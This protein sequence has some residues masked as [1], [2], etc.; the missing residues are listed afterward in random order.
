MDGKHITT[1]V[2]PNKYFG[3]LERFVLSNFDT[4][5]HD[6]K[7]IVIGEYIFRDGDYFR[8]LYPGKRIVFY[9]W[10]Q[11]V[12]NN[13]YF[14]LTDAIRNLKTADEVWDYDYLNVDFL[15]WYGVEVDAIYPF[16]YT[17]ELADLP[18]T[19][20]NPEI[21]VLL[22][23]YLPEIR[24]RKM[25]K[26]MPHLYHNYRVMILSGFDRSQQAKYIANSKIILN[27]HGLE[28]YCRQEQERI[29]YMLINGKCVLS[30]Q[31]QVNYFGDAIVQ[32]P[33]DQLGERIMDLIDLGSWRMQA[34]TGAYIFK[35]NLQR[36][37]ETK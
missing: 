2:T 16:T 1:H 28:P 8:K 25:A 11:M 19:V 9:N 37:W 29:G 17:A 5:A 12:G 34:K 26:I 36:I 23:G 30:E 3:I 10:E 13:N 33:L 35:N 32:A 7:V 18:E 6:G 21:D 27:L 20:I 24:L 14:N 15:R 31:S 4:P 22:F